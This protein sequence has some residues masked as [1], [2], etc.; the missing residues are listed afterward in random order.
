MVPA[1]FFAGMTLPLLTYV[2][3]SRGR[4]EREIGAVYG[5]NTLGAIAGTALGGSRA[6]CR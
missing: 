6:A 5:W 3:Y 1:S 2:L 4:G